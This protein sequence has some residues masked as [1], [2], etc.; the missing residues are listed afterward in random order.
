MSK[1]SLAILLVTL[2]AFGS[3]FHLFGE[4]QDPSKIHVVLVAG[5]PCDDDCDMNYL[6]E[7]V[8]AQTYHLLIE[9]GIPKDNI[10]LFMNGGMVNNTD[11][12]PFPGTLYTDVNKSRNYNEGLQIDYVG[13]DVNLNNYVAVLKGE[14]SEVKGGSGR[15]LKR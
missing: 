14:A 1:L 13:E 6:F 4:D 3:S 7:A 10:I 15:V 12:N 8:I 5:G 11:I 9:S 2:L